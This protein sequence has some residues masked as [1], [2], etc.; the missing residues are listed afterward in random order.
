MVIGAKSSSKQVTLP[1]QTTTLLLEYPCTCIKLSKCIPETSKI[2]F[3]NSLEEIGK[4]IATIAR[5]AQVLDVPYN[6]AW[7]NGPS[8]SPNYGQ[9]L[10][11]FIFFRSKSHSFIP[12]DPS[13]INSHSYEVDDVMRCGTSEML[14][15]FHTS[16]RWQLDALSMSQGTMEKIL[17]DVSWEPR[18]RLWKMVCDEL[19]K[20]KLG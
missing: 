2:T 12:I 11:A 9:S 14:G 16:S 5:V 6:V 3:S 1:N 18:E 13:M 10:I 8:E 7:T 15:L 17:K 20:L 4:A 19:Q